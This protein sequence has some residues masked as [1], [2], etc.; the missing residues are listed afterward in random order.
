VGEKSSI[1]S[2]ICFSN[3]V[4]TISFYGYLGVEVICLFISFELSALKI[5]SLNA[6]LLLFQE[7]EG[8]GEH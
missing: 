2:N 4:G 6:I 7:K 5:L 8:F 1:H 3:C